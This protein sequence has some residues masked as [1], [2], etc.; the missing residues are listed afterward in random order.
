MDADAAA[1]VARNESLAGAS[2]SSFPEVASSPAEGA[3]GASFQAE[4]GGSTWAR[5]RQHSKCCYFDADET[6][7]APFLAG[8]ACPV[9]VKNCIWVLTSKLV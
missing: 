7:V 2:S 6:L 9:A 4:A 3:W 1:V 5:C 8:A